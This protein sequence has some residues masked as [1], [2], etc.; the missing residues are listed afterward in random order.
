M[1]SLTPSGLWTV[2]ATKGGAQDALLVEGAGTVAERIAAELGPRLRTGQRVTAIAR[3]GDGVTVRTTSGRIRA[4][5]A[6]VAVPPPV[7]RAIEHDPPLPDA[8]VAVEQGTYMGSVYKAIAVY[9][10]PF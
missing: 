2:L 4:E 10:R 3:D 8:R 1:R 7:A 9:E 6:I 5:R